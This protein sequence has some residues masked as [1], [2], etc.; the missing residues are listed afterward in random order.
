MTMYPPRWLQLLTKTRDV[1]VTQ[2]G[3]IQGVDSVPWAGGCVTGL[4]QV[5]DRQSEQQTHTHAS[6]NVVS[7]S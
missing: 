2:D 6:S 1:C 4:A 5:L 7:H 3:C